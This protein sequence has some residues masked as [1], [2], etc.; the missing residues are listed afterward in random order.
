MQALEAVGF[1][2][3]AGYSAGAL[4][5][6]RGSVQDRRAGIAASHGPFV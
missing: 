3:A 2:G 1:H 5:I 4:F 6:N